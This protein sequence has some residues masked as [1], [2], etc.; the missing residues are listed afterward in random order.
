MSNKL[1]KKDS[2]IF[3]LFCLRSYTL[4][5]EIRGGGVRSTRTGFS[6][7]ILAMFAQFGCEIE[8]DQTPPHPKLPPSRISGYRVT[9]EQDGKPENR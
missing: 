1:L 9:T 8:D 2:F 3:W 7:L 5:P 6:A 4:Y